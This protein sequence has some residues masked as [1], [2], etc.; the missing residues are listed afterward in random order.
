[1]ER[2]LVLKVL[3]TVAGVLLAYFLWQSAPSAGRL[4]LGLVV[5]TFVAFLP[6]MLLLSNANRRRER[7]ALK[8][9]DTMDQ[10]SI[11]V[12]AGLGFEGAL[13]HVAG[14]TTGP[15]ADEIVRTLQ[16]IQVGVPRRTAYQALSDR[17]ELPALRR[18]IRAIIQAEQHGISIARV[19]QIQ[20]TEMR[21]IRRL[22]AEEKAMRIPVLVAFPMFL[23]IFPALL[24]VVLG[25]AIIN[26][27]DAFT[28]GLVGP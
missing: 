14:N 6:E 16:D 5:G 11:A 8:L 3:G 13:R 21:V 25:P 2:I 15:L 4:L 19:L 17:V 23:C 18:F 28:G 12:E 10:L 20:A 7:I 22:T 9:P 27:I 26:I 1:M 24:V